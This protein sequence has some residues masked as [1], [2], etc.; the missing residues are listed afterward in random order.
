MSNDIETYFIHFTNLP[1]VLDTFF[2][3]CFKVNPTA[4]VPLNEAVA[5]FSKE[6]PKN[7]ADE[8]EVTDAQ[9]RGFM[10]K[11]NAISCDRALGE[12]VKKGM[13]E[14]LHDG[15]DFCFRIANEKYEAY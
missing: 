10:D 11:I 2:T 7:D 13:I 15:E 14:M 6:F 3:G 5:L 1:T 12:L 9:L 4:H 8:H